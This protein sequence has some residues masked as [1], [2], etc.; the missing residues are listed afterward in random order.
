MTSTQ[1]DSGGGRVAEEPSDEARH[2]ARQRI[3]AKRDFFSHLV[4]FVVVNGFLTGVWAM[5]GG[6]F[7]PAW[8]IAA[9]GA[10][11]VLHA[12]D[13]LWRRPVSEAD[14]DRELGRWRS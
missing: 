9:W 12:W 8:V 1:L 13:V 2:R 6:Y 3:Q 11:L 7:W 14:V 10:G 4:A 5:T